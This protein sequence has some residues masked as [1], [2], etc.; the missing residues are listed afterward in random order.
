MNEDK[1]TSFG[2]WVV[3]QRTAAPRHFTQEHLAE[4]IGMS[5]SHLSDIENGKVN[6]PRETVIEIAKALDCAKEIALARAGFKFKSDALDEKAYLARILDNLKVDKLQYAIDDLILLYD[7]INKRKRKR[8]VF[9]PGQMRTQ[10]SD[11]VFLLHE[12]PAWARA[13]VLDYFNRIQEQAAT[14]DA[15]INPSRKIEVIREVK[16]QIQ[17]TEKKMEHHLNVGPTNLNRQKVSIGADV[18]ISV[19]IKTSGPMPPDYSIL[20]I[21]A[22]LVSRPELSFYAQMKP[23]NSN[24][25][26]DVLA[27]N[28]M[29]LE[30]LE[31]LGEDPQIATLRFVEWVREVAG[32]GRPVFVSM[33]A[34]LD[35]SF[36]NWYAHKFAGYNPFGY[37][38]VDIR[39]YE[40]ARSKCSWGAVAIIEDDGELNFWRNHSYYGAQEQAQMFK[41]TLRENTDI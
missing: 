10:I 14:Q 21:E 4:E 25:V 5:R 1:R 15:Q 37:G 30:E 39:T 19:S 6:V 36:I 13:E 38:A 35:W 2:K 11:V 18:Y 32:L 17:E 41:E 33:T 9:D 16:S 27:A 26:P 3:D 34:T 7:L 40:M 12:L 24:A 29:V 31:E 23:L 8:R 22:C 20:S 28:K